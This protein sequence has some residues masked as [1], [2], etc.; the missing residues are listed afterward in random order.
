MPH[1]VSLL[2]P[3]N[4]GARHLI[5][6]AV[7]TPKEFADAMLGL[8]LADPFLNMAIECERLAQA[9]ISWIVNLPSVEQQDVDFE[10]QLADVGLGFHREH[11]NLEIFKAAGFR[12]ATVVADAS[13]AKASALLHP[14]AIII[15]PRITDFA[16]GFPSLRQR[17]STAQEISLSLDGTGWKGMLL[18]LGELS[19]MDHERQWP[20]A[21]D[22][23]ICR[24]QILS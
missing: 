13:S 21:L 23:V 12:I 16:A 7:K 24:P 8:F 19:E 18:G 20:E 10:Q 6:A 9:N 5:D 1:E 14:D 15:L 2:L 22:G 11:N 17:R 4:N 3:T